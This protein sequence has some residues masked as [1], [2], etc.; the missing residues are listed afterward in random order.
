VIKVLANRKYFDRSVW[1]YAFYHKDSTQA[2]REYLSFRD[3]D[4]S[5]RLGTHFSSS[6]LKIDDKNAATGFTRHLEYHPMVNRRAHK[7]GGEGSNRILNRE[8]RQTYDSF[9]TTMA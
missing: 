5:H 7:V 2:M 9:L 8:F 3:R 6:L 1:Q 4:L